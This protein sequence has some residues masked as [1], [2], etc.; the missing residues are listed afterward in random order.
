MSGGS[1]SSVGRARG[2]GQT[3][4]SS[5]ENPLPRSDPWGAYLALS[6]AAGHAAWRVVERGSVDAVFAAPQTDYTRSL[7]DAIP[8][9][10]FFTGQGG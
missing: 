1:V 10:E 4:R 6:R 8:G 9:A 3:A 2:P 5:A 7:L